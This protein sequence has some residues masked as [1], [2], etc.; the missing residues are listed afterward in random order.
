MVIENSDEN[1]QL[2]ILAPSFSTT[3]ETFIRAHLN[4]ICPG[5]TSTI[6]WRGTPVNESLGD[7]P[8]HMMIR[9]PKIHFPRILGQTFSKDDS[10]RAVDFLINLG[11]PVVLVEYGPTASRSLDI[12]LRAGCHFFVHFHGYDASKRLDKAFQRGQY[13]KIFTHA[14]GIIAP[15]RFLVDRLIAVGCPPEKTHVVPCGVETDGF[16]NPQYNP[17]KLIAVGRFTEKKAPLSTIKAFA[18]AAPYFPD[19]QLDYIGDGKL[20]EDAKTLVQQL[21]M[22]DRIILHGAQSHKQVRKMLSQASI[23]LQH[24]VTA[25][26]GDTEGMP[27]AILEAM[28]IGLGI[29]S[30]RHSGI[31]EAITD[32]KE[33]LLVEEHDI[34]GMANAISRLLENQPEARSFGQAAQARFHSEFTLQHTASRL[35]YIMFSDM[36]APIGS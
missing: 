26:D 33:G 15:S 29:V 4:S 28:S 30:T 9:K 10:E 8:P 18:K 11:R 35:H 1:P 14:E 22:K 2:V 27:V 13:K 24:S 25:S 5:K 12:I 32:G 31:P 17:N 6:C 7:L 19:A 23:F 34:D 21:N 36:K 16:P 20:L 3:S